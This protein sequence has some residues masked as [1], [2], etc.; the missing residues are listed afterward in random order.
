MVIM[1]STCDAIFLI[2][3][4]IP[5]DGLGRITFGLQ[6][7]EAQVHQAAL[8]LSLRGVSGRCVRGAAWL[9]LGGTGEGPLCLP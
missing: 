4:R 9:G 2:S 8:G 7:N 5:I 1:I 3:S 6:K